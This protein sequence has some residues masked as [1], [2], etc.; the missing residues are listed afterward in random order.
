[1][2]YFFLISLRMFVLSKKHFFHG[3]GRIGKSHNSQNRQI[4][5]GAIELGWLVV[6][7]LWHINL[8]RL[9][10]AKP[11]FIQIITSL[12]VYTVQL[13]KTFLFQATQFSQTVLTQTI[14]FSMSIVFIC[15]QLNAKTV[16]FQTIQ[17]SLR[18]V[19]MAKASQFSISTQFSSIKPKSA[20]R[21]YHPRPEWTWE[22]WQRRGALHC[23]NL[24]IRLFSVISRTSYTSAVMQSVYSTALANWA[25]LNWG[26]K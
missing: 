18:T 25:K 22:R 6:W 23:P 4:L 10:I 26:K 11:I 19:S 15:K 8:C 3:I 13:P 21:C 1:M 9:F 20:I 17:F 24:T 16:L 14:Q 7:V 5:P 2:S 12:S